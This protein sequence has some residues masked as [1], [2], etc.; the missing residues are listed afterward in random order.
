MKYC[1]RVAEKRCGFDSDYLSPLTFDH[2]GKKNFYLAACRLNTKW[3]KI[4]S[5]VENCELLCLNCHM[6]KNNL[7]NNKRK[8]SL[9][10]EQKHT[11]R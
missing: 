6:I 8:I 5:E 10:E 3:E 9:D 1:V 7:A 11:F 2:I 4:L